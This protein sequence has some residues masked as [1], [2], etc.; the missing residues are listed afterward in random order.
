[1]WLVISSGDKAKFSLEGVLIGAVDETPDSNLLCTNPA[2]VMGSSCGRQFASRCLMDSIYS[3]S[4]AE[5]GFRNR[6]GV[7]AFCSPFL[8]GCLCSMVGLS[9]SGI[10]STSGSIER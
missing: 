10:I 6:L 2:E 8:L 5:K 9:K 7:S 1:V 3:T 4:G